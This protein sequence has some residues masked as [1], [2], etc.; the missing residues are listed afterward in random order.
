MKA[1]IIENEPEILTILA[2]SL[3]HGGFVVSTASGGREGIEVALQVHPDVILLDVLMPE[4]DGYETCRAIKRHP[5]LK[6]VPVVFMS[7]KVEPRDIRAAFDAGAAA[8]LGKPFDPLT[9]AAKILQII[10]QV[11][12]RA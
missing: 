7:A 11:E 5:V 12:E 10:G 4:M 2:K 8:C 3:K 6:D 1:L 9:L